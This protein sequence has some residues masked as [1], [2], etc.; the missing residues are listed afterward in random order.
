MSCNKIL[1]WNCSATSDLTVVYDLIYLFYNTGYTALSYL[2]PTFWPDVQI[3]LWIDRNEDN[4]II[5]R[6]FQTRS[7]FFSK[8]SK[9]CSVWVVSSG[10]SVV[11]LM[12][13]VVLFVRVEVDYWDTTTYSYFMT[14]LQKNRFD[15]F[16]TLRLVRITSSNQIKNWKIL[17]FSSKL[18]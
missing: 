10:F 13:S 6:L 11:F 15:C 14:Y 18:F 4:A 1:T 2:V 17:K 3:N 5:R 8:H 16:R 9:S 7:I 12:S